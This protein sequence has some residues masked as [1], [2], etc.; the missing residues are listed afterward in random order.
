MATKER[1]YTLILG[2]LITLLVIAFL[3]FTYCPSLY[4]SK[5]HIKNMENKLSNTI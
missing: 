1:V 4:V 5:E 2:S 3:I